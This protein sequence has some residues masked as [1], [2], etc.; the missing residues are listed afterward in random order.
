V[1]LKLYMDVHVPSAITE[2]LRSRGVDV[3]RAQ[4]DGASRLPDPELLDR[5][6]TLGRLLFSE[7]EDLLREAARRQRS[8]EPFSGV[9]YVHQLKLQIGPCIDELELI[10]AAGRPEEFANRVEYLSF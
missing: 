5:A 2:G 10:A 3:L 4:E 6:S 1:S 8:G 7:D 9:I